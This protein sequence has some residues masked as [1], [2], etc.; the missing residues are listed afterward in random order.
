MSDH[1]ESETTAEEFDAM[2]DQANSEGWPDHQQEQERWVMV[3][4]GLKGEELEAI[5]WAANARGVKMSE[6]LRECGLEKASQP[7]ITITKSF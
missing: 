4:V 7:I 5:E 3:T 1:D 6:F 2:W